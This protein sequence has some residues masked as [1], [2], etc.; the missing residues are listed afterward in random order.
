MGLDF[1][2]LNRAVEYLHRLA[3]NLQETAQRICM[4]KFPN[5]GET[6][7]MIMIV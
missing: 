6:L 4:D 1:A 5:Y 2:T 7:H 3:A